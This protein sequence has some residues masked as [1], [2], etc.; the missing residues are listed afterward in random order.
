MKKPASVHSGKYTSGDFHGL[1]HAKRK[2]HLI[3]FNM[4]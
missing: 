1:F 2:K 4:H 3:T